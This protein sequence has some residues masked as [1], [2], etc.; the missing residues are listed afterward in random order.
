MDI[1]STI[2][3]CEPDCQPKARGVTT[4]AQAKLFGEN[5]EYGRGLETLKSRASKVLLRQN[6]F[7]P[8]SSPRASITL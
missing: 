5:P 4:K 1:S 8:S 7:G 6:H 2:D 3:S